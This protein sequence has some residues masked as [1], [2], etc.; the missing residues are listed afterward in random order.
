MWET[1]R[2]ETHTTVKKV[3]LELLRTEKERVIRRKVSSC[4]G[5]LA[6]RILVKGEWPELMPLL[7]EV[8]NSP[9]ALHRES[10]LDILD[11]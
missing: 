5:T 1:T 9:H 3:L 11:K 4:I 10:A 6:G 7:A 2:P 8:L